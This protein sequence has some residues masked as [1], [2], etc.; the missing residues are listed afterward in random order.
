MI[1]LII[2]IINKRIAQQFSIKYYISENS[3]TI[4]LTN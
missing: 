2:A 4:I 3:V 1:L